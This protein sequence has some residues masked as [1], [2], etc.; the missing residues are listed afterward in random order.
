VR[1]DEQ[2]QNGL[3][4]VDE[5]DR[6]VVVTLRSPGSRFSLALLERLESLART[7]KSRRE[8]GALLLRA[9]GADFSHGADLK[10]PGMASLV[11][12]DEQSRR[13]LAH[14]GQSLVETWMTLPFPTVASCQGRVVGAGAC[15]MMASS[16]RFVTPET[17]C[18]FPEVD[19]GM[20]L[21][22]GILPRLVSELG[23]AWTRRLVLAGESVQVASMK[24]GAW[25]VHSSDDLDREARNFAHAL[26]LKPSGSVRHTLETMHA[27]ESAQQGLAAD[28]AKRFA[29]TA[30]GHEFKEAVM[31]FLGMT[32]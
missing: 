4:K 21:S 6:V 9:E 16:F 12:G 2:D 29:L 24:P 19:L 15:V 11:L 30:G 5:H 1:K 10:D 7:W 17:T 8:L 23:P 20:S 27:L 32:K 13:R 28:D 31:R 26:A 25:S 18:R 14:L 3:L 22:W